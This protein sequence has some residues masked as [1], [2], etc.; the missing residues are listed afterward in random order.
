[1]GRIKSFLAGFMSIVLMIGLIANINIVN[2]RAEGEGTFTLEFR[3]AT[4][5]DN[6]LT[7]TVDGKTWIVT[8]NGDLPGGSKW[9]TEGSNPELENIPK[10][11]SITFVLSE[12][13]S[14]DGATPKPQMNFD[15]ET[16][17][18][19]DG[20]S[21][22]KS[23]NNVSSSPVRVDFVSPNNNN[24]NNPGGD[25]KIIEFRD[26]SISG[27]KATYQVGSGEDAKPV[28][29][30][31]FVNDTHQ[32][33]STGDH[34]EINLG[35]SSTATLKFGNFDA[36]T[37]QAILRG[38]N[39]YQQILS[40]TNG[41][42]SLAGLNFPSPANLSVELKNNNNPPGPGGEGP[43]GE[44][45][46]NWIN[47]SEDEKVTVSFTGSISG[48]KIAGNEIDV[49]NNTSPI[50]LDKIKLN[51][52]NTMEISVYSHPT[53]IFTSLFIND[54]QYVQKGDAKD[55]YEI[56]LPGDTKIININASTASNDNDFTIVW[57]YKLDPNLGPECLVEHGKVEMVSGYKSGNDSYY[58]VEKDSTVT[59]K[60]IPD[61]GYQ[62][63]GARLNGDV[64]L[65]PDNNNTSQFTFTM[66]DT[67]IHFKGVFKKTEDLIE[68]NVS[69]VVSGTTFTGKD[70]ASTGGT[71]KMTLNSARASDTNVVSK[72]I[73]TTKA[74]KA[75]DIKM[76]QLFYKNNNVDMW[77][78]QK[79]DL[80]SEATVSL[81]VTG[82]A[83]VGYA[84]LREHN[85]TVE[86]IPA[87]Y[88]PDTNTITFKSAKYS[89]YTLVPLRETNNTL[90][91][92][93]PEDTQN[94][95]S[96]SEAATTVEIPSIEIVEAEEV[97]RPVQTISI[98]KSQVSL[99][100]NKELSGKTYNLSSYITAKGFT[101]AIE[102]IVKSNP[103]EK[104]ISI[105]TSKPIC[106][107]KTMLSNITKTKADVVYYFMHKGHLYSVTIP[108]NTD[109]Q[110]IF[111]KTSF[112]GPLYVG[113][114]LGT[115]RLIK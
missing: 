84:V 65:S 19:G 80:D 44:Q 18:F 63:V 76:D 69:S 25:N 106:F 89:I 11:T 88:N 104:R 74:I 54:T 101:T 28:T 30:E 50:V 77:T 97:A 100:A 22:T 82:D 87:N 34:K 95:N 29:V 99:E 83:S 81:T 68:N 20:N 46:G 109:V 15:G 96:K 42:A 8:I 53:I 110:K 55:H 112:Q 93:K 61:Y 62:V 92:V 10:D 58:I 24:N 33:I 38:S 37:M 5:V 36:G 40:V 79:T 27:G 57:T 59:V 9:K 48:L 17:S 107:T 16:M 73:D 64:D 105:Y 111:G 49:I 66:P 1:M 91:D 94:S 12:T 115:S 114:V 35:D 3:D 47:L 23:F 85:G 2:A 26:A 67:N 51:S 86:E 21:F 90:Q 31:V 39:N 6:A 78:T 4:R 52:D 113:K 103:N 102:K 41:M 70:I 14:T 71:A 45:G 32:D 98:D 43:G 13:G 72:E 56:S 75:V 7:F 108:A 60:L